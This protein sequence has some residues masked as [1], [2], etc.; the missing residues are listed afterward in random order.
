MSLRADAVLFD[1][2]GTLFE[3]GATWNAWGR[4]ALRD[5]SG[6]DGDAL[7]ALAAASRFDLER[8]VFLPDSPIIAGTNREAAECLAG[9]LP[10]LV[11]DEVERYLMLA[12]AEA[13]LVEAAPLV[14][15]MARLDG[16]GLPLG[17][18]TNDAEF[19]ARAHLR[20]AGIEQAF[21]F[22]AGFDSGHGAKPDPA[23]LLAFARAVGMVP[24][25]I[26]MVGDSPHDLTAGRAAGMQTV[27]VLTGPIAAEVLAPH[28]D[29][30]L[31][32]IGHLPDWLGAA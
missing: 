25:R 28:A 4:D 7:L 24:E 10:H 14:A 27:A 1:K 26:V 11:A 5:L 23:P 9:A 16:L 12:A 22:I 30:I 29:V 31:P 32:H 8:E 20:A 19:A 6:G 21:R 15:L 17:V 18:M 2:D 13:P 3:F